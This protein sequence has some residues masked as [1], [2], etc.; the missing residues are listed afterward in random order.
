M[1]VVDID[2]HRPGW[3]VCEPEC[4]ICGRDWV[5]VVHPDHGNRG[6]AL[7]QCPG[8]GQMSGQL[9]H[10]WVRDGEPVYA[11]LPPS[12]DPRAL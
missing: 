5:A 8:C 9:F 12:F 3:V 10:V 4:C 1:K 11:P 2:A 7:L 6:W